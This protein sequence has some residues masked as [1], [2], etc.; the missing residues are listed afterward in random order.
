MTE[1]FCRN[2]GAEVALDARFCGQCGSVTT[3]VSKEVAGTQQVHSTSP[4]KRHFKRESNQKMRFWRG[5]RK[6][7][8]LLRRRNSKR[9]L[10]VSKKR[11]RSPLKI[12]DA[13]S[14]KETPLEN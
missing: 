13:G 3:P 12:V 10:K 6:E 9:R 8:L 7:I 1:R 5:L 14:Q 11:S 2:W 4:I